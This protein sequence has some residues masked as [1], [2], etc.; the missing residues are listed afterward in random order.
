MDIFSDAAEEIVADPGIPRS[1]PS[2]DEEPSPD[3]PD[4]GVHRWNQKLLE[5][6][7]KVM[8]YEG[9][10]TYSDDAFLT[11]LTD[12]FLV[13]S[14]DTYLVLVPLL[15]V[16]S[17]IDNV[18]L[19]VAETAVHPH[20]NDPFIIQN[21]RVK[22]FSDAA[23]SA[24]LT[25]EGFLP[26]PTQDLYASSL[27]FNLPSHHLLI[28]FDGLY[29]TTF[30]LRGSDM[31]NSVTSELLLE[32]AVETADR[33]LAAMR[34]DEPSTY[35]G[36]GQAYIVNRD[37]RTYRDDINS[38][39]LHR[40]WTARY[41][42]ELWNSHLTGPNY[43]VDERL[44]DHLQR[45]WKR[46]ASEISF[47]DGAPFERPLSR[48][49][50]IYGRSSPKD[51]LV[52]AVIVF[53]GVLRK[54][55][56]IGGLG[57]TMALIGSILLDGRTGR[58]R[59]ELRS[60]FRSLYHA[61]SAIVHKDAQW[62]SIIDSDDFDPVGDVDPSIREFVEET[63]DVV[64]ETILAYMDQRARNNRSIGDTNTLIYNAMRDAGSPN[65]GLES[66]SQAVSRQVFDLPSDAAELVRL[67]A[68]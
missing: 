8:D 19:D 67:V 18:P 16:V 50:E 27:S 44:A 58:S 1:I 42:P 11:A 37:W 66:E 5:F 2:R 39:D 65:L 60:F 14:D 47:E 48:F 57:A 32:N 46:Y 59:E 64:S 25:Y 24:I 7:W 29:D 52:D 20:E 15:N 54:G 31:G 21:L 33:V 68:D 36:A 13:D 30:G 51:Q 38:I 56:E 35:P 61:R 34:L 55:V 10:F 23:L 41:D 9:D 43:E 4:L 62:D 6:A 45:F 22:R 17:N 63:R 26:D 49:N 3:F 40:P 12:H 53:E 28:E